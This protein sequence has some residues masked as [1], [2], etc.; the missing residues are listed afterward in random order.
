MTTTALAHRYLPRGTSRDLFELHDPEILISGPAGTGKS[1]A[2][3]EKLNAL[4]LRYPGM[5]ALIVRKTATSLGTT[6]LKTWERF[7]VPELMSNF[8][9]TFYG[10]S[11]REA[12]Q[13][14]YANG[15]TVT[16]GGLDKPSRIMSSEYDVI[17]CQE[18]TELTIN[19]W[20]ALTTRLRSWVMPY[21]QLIADCNPERPTHWL[22]GRA[23][24][25]R[26][27]LIESRHED[28]PELFSDDGEL[29]ERG[30]DYIAKLDALTGPRYLRLR[31]GIW[32]AAEGLVYP[33]FDPALHVLDL[34][35]PPLEWPRYWSID[36]G[37]TNPFVCQWW[38][39][40]PDGR[41]YLYREIYR[42][43]RTVADHAARILQAVMHK[44]KRLEGWKEPRPTVVVADHDAEGRAV[45]ERELGL[46]IT[47]A[48]KTVTEG[49]QAV[50]ERLKPAA[51]GKPRLFVH[52]N[53]LIDADAELVDSKRPTCT[54]DEFTGY[55]WDGN[56]EKPKETPVKAD[57][58]G[59]DA[60]RY[61][62]AHF[63]L[64]PAYGVRF[65]D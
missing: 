9:V 26:T 60:M 54:L 12:P 11:P 61:L 6:A 18:A 13:Y 17:Y 2:C 14:R 32:A 37:F 27:L 30:A 43:Q 53:A 16:I 40:D 65:L 28:N 34:L 59:M 46:G 15:S 33:E 8:T 51:D 48:I 19:D 24:E 64:R 57:D 29:T 50:Q 58:H 4:C 45:L 42:T 38:A 41:L 21:Q 47:P 52:R 7:V 62:V 31:K 49:I 22:R 5:R 3:L 20:E 44:G 55:V 63:D 25:G 39:E 56:A 1:R 35:P 10:G 36:F 23:M